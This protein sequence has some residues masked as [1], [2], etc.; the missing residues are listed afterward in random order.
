MPQLGTPSHCLTAVQCLNLKASN[1][2]KN[3]AL[4]ISL[5]AF[6]RSSSQGCFLPGGPVAVSGEVGPVVAAINSLRAAGGF[7]MVGIGQFTSNNLWGQDE[8]HKSWCCLCKP[9][10]SPCTMTS[11][12]DSEGLFGTKKT[13]G[14][15]SELAPQY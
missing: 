7:E 3:Q 2:L 4:R 1:G 11:D 14:G 6:L 12:S 13:G 10:S 5:C 15:P 9:C 8:H